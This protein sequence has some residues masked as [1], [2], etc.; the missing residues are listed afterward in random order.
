MEVQ[1]NDSEC[2]KSGEGSFFGRVH[3][4]Q[5]NICLT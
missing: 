3:V 4:I 5:D 1:G 2:E